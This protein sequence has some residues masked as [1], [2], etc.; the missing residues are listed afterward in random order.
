MIWLELTRTKNLEDLTIK[1]TAVHNPSFNTIFVKL[2]GELSNAILKNDN[3]LIQKKLAMFQSYCDR[4]LH[5]LHVPSVRLQD[6]TK[7][8]DKDTVY[9]EFWFKEEELREGIEEIFAELDVD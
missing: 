4:W 3:K 7:V 6:D 1:T 5:R 9:E 2:T 8:L